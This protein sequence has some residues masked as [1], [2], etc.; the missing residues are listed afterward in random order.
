MDGRI[1][2][3]FILT[4]LGF[5]AEQRGDAAEALDLHRQG[6]GEAERGGDPRA[7][8]LALEGLAGARSWRGSTGPRPNSWTVPAPCA[9]GSACRCPR[10]S[11]GTSTG[12]PS[13]SGRGPAPAERGQGEKRRPGPG[14]GVGTARG[15]AVPAGDGGHRRQ[16]RTSDAERGGVL[17][18]GQRVKSSGPRQGPW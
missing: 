9:T 7:V 2:T 13:A 15:G 8:A 6:L 3:A 12:S 5:V 11:A 16:T 14:T 1:G 10:P 18:P 17:A 4:Q